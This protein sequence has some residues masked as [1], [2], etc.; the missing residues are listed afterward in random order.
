MRA[1]RE[2]AMSDPTDVEQELRFIY[3]A[4]GDWGQWTKRA[5]TQSAAL[6]IVGRVEERLG[7]RLHP[8]VALLIQELGAGTFADKSIALPYDGDVRTL[9]AL[10]GEEDAT[11]GAGGGT[12][13]I[14]WHLR[15][16]EGDLPPGLVPIMSFMDGALAVANSDATVFLWDPQT[17]AGDGLSFVS[18]S[19]RDFFYMFDVTA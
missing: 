7:E 2:E 8:L 19:L 13:C 18:S 17:Y 16:N 12:N 11:D 14:L 1:R 6:G 5:G 10:L 3:G 4:I 15:M 9:R